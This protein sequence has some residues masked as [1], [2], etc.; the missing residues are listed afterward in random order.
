MAAVVVL[1]VDRFDHYCPWAAGPIGFGNYRHFLLFLA[2]MFTGCVFM[3][4][5][6][7][8]PAY[9]HFSTGIP[10][11]LRMQ[12]SAA[13][14]LPAT[15]GCAVGLLLAWHLYLTAT[16]QTTI[17]VFHNQAR[18]QLARSQGRVRSISNGHMQLADSLTQCIL[19]VIDTALGQRIRSGLRFAQLS[20][21]MWPIPPPDRVVLLSLPSRRGGKWI[22]VAH[23]G[24]A[25]SPV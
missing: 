21:R 22:G 16:N 20:S 24:E 23:E 7:A 1:S 9:G 19:S 8:L 15:V 5:V 18:E 13:F 17:E 25:A 3:A 6:S 11:G 4:S 12:T 2:Y 10:V 14:A